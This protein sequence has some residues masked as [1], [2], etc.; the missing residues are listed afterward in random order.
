MEVPTLD[1]I[2][3][4]TQSTYSEASGCFGDVF[5]VRG[6]AV[7]RIAIH[8]QNKKV[9]ER[10]RAVLE[11][12]RTDPTRSPY[13]VDYHG[14]FTDESWAYLVFTWEE[15]KLDT[16]Y[17]DRNFQAVQR[18]LM[19]L[20]EAIRYLHSKNLVHRDIKPDNVLLTS[21]NWSAATVKLADFGFSKLLRP[22]DSNTTG[23]G[24]PY[25]AAPE[26]LHSLRNYGNKVD[27]WSFGVVA[28]EVM[29]GVKPFPA[30]TMEELKM[31]QSAGVPKSQDFPSGFVD[32]C[33]EFVEFCMVHSALHRPTIDD[34][35][36]HP[37]F[38][39]T[40]RLFSGLS[41]IREADILLERIQRFKQCLRQAGMKED[42][43]EF[44]SAAMTVLIPMG[45]ACVRVKEQLPPREQDVEEATAVLER[46]DMVQR[47]E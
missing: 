14:C 5:R 45:Q 24:T 19:Q 2:R 46:I 6:Y 9:I 34:V 20:A 22:D 15:A 18:I 40:P 13:L 36:R 23:I 33:Q 29:T 38:D 12:I 43:Q 4:A 3:T 39:L 27:V 30:K 16:R 26:I 41:I 1:E 28:Y 32:I 44:T 8:L 47:E 42:Y 35:L 31:L 10:E 25:Y 37:F 11:W 17:S 21:P 7:K